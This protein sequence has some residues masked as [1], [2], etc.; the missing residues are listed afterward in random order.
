[1]T[2]LKE[3][4]LGKRDQDGTLPSAASDETIVSVD[5]E[6]SVASQRNITDSVEDDLVQ[7]PSKSKGTIISLEEMQRLK[8][9]VDEC[10]ANNIEMDLVSV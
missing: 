2:L 7:K 5:H 8:D 1:M 6:F 9:K 4:E 3:I 10:L